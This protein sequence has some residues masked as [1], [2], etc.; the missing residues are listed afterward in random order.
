[1]EIPLCAA[2]FVARLDF[3]VCRLV[4]AVWSVWWVWWVVVGAFHTNP[5]TPPTSS[6]DQS[7]MI[8][9]QGSCIIIPKSNSG[10][11]QIRRKQSATRPAACPATMV[12]RLPIV[13]TS[14]LTSCH[15]P[16]QRPDL[17]QPSHPSLR[18]PCLIKP[19]CQTSGRSHHIIQ[20]WTIL[21]TS[22]KSTHKRHTH[23][24]KRPVNKLKWP[25]QTR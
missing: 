12:D 13:D 3:A 4:C 1:M 11:V 20:F 22:T 16:R 24:T 5:E 21:P 14:G 18:L 6:L 25:S 8:P 2:L 19:V 15:H 10:S 7:T 9:P 17:H 23:Q